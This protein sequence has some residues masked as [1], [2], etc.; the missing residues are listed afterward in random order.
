MNFDPN[1]PNLI[2]LILKTVSPNFPHLILLCQHQFLFWL[3]SLLLTFGASMGG[4]ILEVLTDPVV[5]LFGIVMD[6]ADK[7]PMQ[8]AT[9]KEPGF[10]LV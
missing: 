5:V 9:I 10:R 8:T 7:F 4:T 6:L 2:S 1:L 3:P